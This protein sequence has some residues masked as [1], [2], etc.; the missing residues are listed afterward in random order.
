MRLLGVVRQPEEVL[1]ITFTRKAANEMRY[2][3]LKAMHNQA[4]EA[5]AA[6]IQNQKSKWSIEDNPQR[7]KI[8]TIDSFSYSLVQRMP[9]ASQ[10]GLEYRFIDNAT[11]QYKEAAHLTLDRIE[12]K[13]V[14]HQTRI[15]EFLALLDNNFDRAVSLIQ[16]M[17]Q[18]RDQWV[19][20]IRLITSSILEG[21][22]EQLVDLLNHG[23][24]Q[25]F[26]D[27]ITK[28][29]NLLT[30]QEINT[31]RKLCYFAAENLECEFNNLQTADD[32]RFLSRT[33]FTQGRTLRNAV[34]KTHGFPSGSDEQKEQWKQIASAISE[35]DIAS[36]IAR[37]QYLPRLET[38]SEEVAAIE[39][40]SSVLAF[41]LTELS[42]LFERTELVDFKQLA[43]A[44]HRA[45]SGQDA[46][47]ELALAMD[48][49]ISHILVDEFQDTSIA[50]YNLLESLISEWV[51]GDGNSF[52]AVGDPMQSIYRFR[53]ADLTLFQKVRDEGFPTID[54]ESIQLVTNFRSS[55]DVV[56]WNN[57]IYSDLFI[58]G[59]DST[60]G[61][62][63]FAESVAA[64]AFDGKIKH[65]LFS[66]DENGTLQARYVVRLIENLKL[67]Y[68]DHTVALLVIN[69][70]ALPSFFKAMRERN[71]T[72]RGVEIES[73]TDEPV[74]RDLHIL[75]R[76]IEDLED[77]LAWLSLFRSPL[78]GIKLKDLEI[79][80]QFEHGLEML[81][82]RDINADDRK[83]MDCVKPLF[84]EAL[85]DHHRTLRSRVERLWFQLGGLDAYEGADTISNGERYLD[86]LEKHLQEGGDFEA[87]WSRVEQLYASQTTKDADVDVMTVHRAK[88]L[89]FD[90]VILPA[91]EK[92][93]RGQDSPLL[94]WRRSNRAEDF[95]IATKMESSEPTLYNWLH[96]EERINDGNEKRRLLYVATTR[97][98]RTL[99]LFGST[100]DGRNPNS[101][102]PLS[103]LLPYFDE[104][105]PEII[106]ELT[107]IGTLVDASR[108]WTKLKRSYRWK[109]PKLERVDDSVLARSRLGQQDPDIDPIG[110]YAEL[111][112]GDL[113]HREL[114]RITVEQ[115]K[116]SVSSR[117]V[118]YWR[119]Y[120]RNKGFVGTELGWLLEQTTKQIDAV[121]HDAD[122]QWLLFGPHRSRYCEKSYTAHFDNELQNIRVD[123]TFITADGVR[124]V[125]DHKTVLINPD[126][127]E[128]I[129][130]EVVRYTPT[131]QNY[132]K[133]LN[134]TEARKT[135]TALYFTAIPKL[136]VTDA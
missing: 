70:N 131:L 97:A 105:E 73:L 40:I 50:Q 126:D 10:F 22:T 89:E 111:A 55:P 124:W 65:L 18:S 88:G 107:K 110:T 30:K 69:R 135:I 38:D 7:L 98:I 72:W 6:L 37:I 104:A 101:R 102:S 71:V 87:L 21:R 95:L 44:A 68:P 58:S 118:T 108:E 78:F 67:N 31:A 99:H 39:K 86:L 127:Q 92:G 1:A 80:A 60:L 41:A 56:N 91:L 17:L 29:K 81:E 66:D 33:F 46:P 117:R 130:G 129:R 90:H 28:V 62:V 14:L 132:R 24:E 20:F 3:V 134:A 94:H 106:D 42:D 125:V 103:L 19:D 112:L 114:M 25:L 4:P 54:L 121:I 133:I 59:Q 13:D 85:N 119:N 96:D 48:Y 49:R 35:K 77:K 36:A 26:A 12:S 100:V 45:I 74:V 128:Q 64:H 15:V 11:S 57:K 43:F 136:V 27:Q 93:S 75:A 122:G 2:R 5:E 123:L 9:Y 115:D 79:L 32:W 51:P 23:R 84:I 52:F 61:S 120:L 63:E 53:D 113:V 82:S 76:V 109:Q 47:T 83:R 34:N 8:Q 16:A 116:N